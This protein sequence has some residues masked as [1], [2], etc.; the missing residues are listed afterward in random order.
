MRMRLSRGGSRALRS[1]LPIANS[2]A[3]L[4]SRKA[5]YTTAG[6]LYFSAV[7]RQTIKEH[8]LKIFTVKVSLFLSSLEAVNLCGAMNREEDGP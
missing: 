5:M 7:I 8:A 6:A 3:R 1:F 2:A 4:I